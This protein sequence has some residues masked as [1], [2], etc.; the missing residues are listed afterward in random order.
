MPYALDKTPLI[1]SIPKV[2]HA[3]LREA[4]RAEG[5]SMAELLRQALR[6]Q[7]GLDLETGEAPPTTG[8]ASNDHQTRV[9]HGSIPARR[10]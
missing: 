6:A 5:V 10:S 7:L 2:L 4:A 3:Q 8:S 1:A 9:R